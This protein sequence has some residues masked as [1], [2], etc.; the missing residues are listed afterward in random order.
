MIQITGLKASPEQT[1]NMPDPD[2]GIQINF[3]LYFR[4]RTRN[5][6]FDLTYGSFT[7]KGSKIVLSPNLIYQ[8]FRLLPFG[9]ACAGTDGIEPMFINDFSTE[10]VFLYLLTTAERDQVI[11]DVNA[12]VLA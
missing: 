1:F 4:P 2:K 7:L 11:K 6:Y 12:G 5:W 10:R 9:L 3:T 8:Y